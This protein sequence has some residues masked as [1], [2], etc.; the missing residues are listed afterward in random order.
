MYFAHLVYR[1]LFCAIWQNSVVK[2]AMADNVEIFKS[3]IFL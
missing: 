2:V 3:S 1:C